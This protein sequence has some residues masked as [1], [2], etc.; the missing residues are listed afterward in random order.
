MS[1]LSYASPRAPAPICL[2]FIIFERA[3]DVN[4]KYEHPSCCDLP[5][6]RQHIHPHVALQQVYMKQW[7][8]KRTYLTRTDEVRNA[9]YYCI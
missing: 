8:K 2:T 5:G 4:A 1:G 3:E 9:G 6:D 7:E